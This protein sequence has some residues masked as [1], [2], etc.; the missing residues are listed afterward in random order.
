MAIAPPP[1]KFYKGYMIA[2][3]YEIEEEDAWKI[4]QRNGTLVAG[5]TA[6]R[7]RRRC[8]TAIWQGG[9]TEPSFSRIG[10]WP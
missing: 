9:G 7:R 1:G 8:A 5:R 6:S 2:L 10:P 4:L 3:D